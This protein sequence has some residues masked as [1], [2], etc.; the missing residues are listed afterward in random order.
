MK[1]I[2]ELVG[3]LDISK[4]LKDQELEINMLKLEI[5]LT[6]KRLRKLEKMY[7][8]TIPQS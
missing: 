7:E 3:S 5:M 2:K 6:Q 8:K 1:K 4:R